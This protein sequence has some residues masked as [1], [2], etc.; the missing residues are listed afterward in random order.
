MEVPKAD[1]IA[2][3][4][5]DILLRQGF[6]PVCAGTPDQAGLEII[7][8]AFPNHCFP[9]AAVHECICNSPQELSAS[10]GFIAGITGSLMRRSG[11]AIWIGQEPMIYP[12][13]LAA[14]GIATKDLIFI[15]TK[16]SKDSCWALEEALKC[17]GLS[18]VI[19]EI[20]DLSF[21]ESR[22]LQ[23]AVEQ[24]GVTGFLLRTK[25]RNLATAS[26]TRWRIS[27]LATD[28]EQELPGL[29]FPRWKVELLK[30]RNGKPGSWDLEWKQ[31]RFALV[32]K[33]QLIAAGLRKAG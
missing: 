7:A 29:G 9:L 5:K 4:Q 12:P 15:R 21:T 22:R 27:H 10:A 13:A 25:P 31:G 19:G 14:F 26:V 32:E 20:S 17:T 33:Q 24:S 6:K 18:A 30:V 23:L 3:L 8:H 16:K 2:A 1:I 11:P 28:K